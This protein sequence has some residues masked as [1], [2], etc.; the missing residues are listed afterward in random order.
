MLRRK[1]DECCE[2]ERRRERHAQF[3]QPDTRLL[4]ALRPEP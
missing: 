3:Q 4:P 1:A 2:A